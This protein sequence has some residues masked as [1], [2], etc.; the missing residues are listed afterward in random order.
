MAA[1][2]KNTPTALLFYGI[3]KQFDL[4]ISLLNQARP[5]YL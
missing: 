1:L 3:K 4:I 5:K 2:L